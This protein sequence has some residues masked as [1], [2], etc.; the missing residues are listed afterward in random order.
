MAIAAIDTFLSVFFLG[1]KTVL[2]YLYYKASKED[3]SGNP[4]PSNSSMDSYKSMGFTF[5]F[6]KGQDTT[7]LENLLT[8]FG[9]DATSLVC[10]ALLLWYA[11]R[12]FKFI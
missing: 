7:L 8:S 3:K 11:I 2:A 5:Q 9:A 1:G 4:Y 12:H 6:I 10:S